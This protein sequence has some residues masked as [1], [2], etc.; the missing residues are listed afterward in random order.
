MAL[1]KSAVAASNN[2]YEGVNKASKQV[3]D[4]VEAN[5]SKLTE[6]AKAARNVA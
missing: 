4:V 6:G 3:A 1:V 5:V 2:A